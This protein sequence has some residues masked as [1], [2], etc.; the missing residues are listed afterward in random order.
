MRLE[1]RITEPSNCFSDGSPSGATSTHSLSARA[2]RALNLW[3]IML[4]TK[5]WELQP[6]CQLPAHFAALFTIEDPSRRG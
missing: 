4:Q 2:R 1:L 6:R 3:R 5:E